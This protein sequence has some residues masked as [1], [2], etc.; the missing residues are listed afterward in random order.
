MKPMRMNKGRERYPKAHEIFCP[1]PVFVLDWLIASGM[2]G[3]GWQEKRMLE[4]K[5]ELQGGNRK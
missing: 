2:E 1:T 3:W 4:I 5:M